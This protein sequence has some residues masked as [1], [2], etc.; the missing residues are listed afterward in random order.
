MT[1]Y[2]ATKSDVKKEWVVIDA[3]GQV[4][5]RVAAKAASILRGKT[6]PTYTP[7]IDC[8][9]NVIIINAQEVRLS[10]KKWEDKIYYRHTGYPGGI[11]SL[12]AQQIKDRRP[13]ELI[14]KAVRG[15]LP[16]NRLGRVQFGNFRVY[17]DAK[18]PH[19]GQNPKEAS[20]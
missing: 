13:Q 12:T 14:R 3:K 20:V 10:G 18:H 2:C 5:G 9:D 17:A 15:M 1:S 11:K 8:G 6:K 4:L 7:H 19:V 16:K